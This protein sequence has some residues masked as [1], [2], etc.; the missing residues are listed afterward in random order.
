MRDESDGLEQRLL[1]LGFLLLL[2][3]LLTG[4][5]IPLLSSPRM[6]LSSHLQGVLNGVL[7]ILLG[8]VWSRLRLSQGARRLTFG[9]AIYG[10]FANWLA[11]LLAAIW[12]AGTMIPIASGGAQSG[13]LQ[14]AVISFLLLSLSFA[15]VALCGLLLWGLRHGSRLGRPEAART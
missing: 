10:T 1:Q 12:N 14:E 13:P 6:G 4:F 15:M 5:A 8:L 7:L 11:T 3:G 9:L 2:L